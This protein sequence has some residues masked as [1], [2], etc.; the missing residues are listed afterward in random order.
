MATEQ[1]KA[2][3]QQAPL[4]PPGGL[5]VPQIPSSH[6]RD[7]LFGCFNDMATCC[8]GCWCPCYLYGKN[9]ENIKQDGF[10]LHCF[11]WFCLT[12]CAPCFFANKTRRQIRDK[13]GIM[14]PEPCGDCC[15]HCF[16]GH[17]AICQEARQLKD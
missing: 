13:Y 9:A 1:V 3:E 12:P 6:F 10:L 15:V 14:E 4:P 11:L 17:C 2:M 5:P 7:S 8:L 16:C